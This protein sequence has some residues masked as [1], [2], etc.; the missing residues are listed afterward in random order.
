MGPKPLWRPQMDLSARWLINHVWSRIGV[1]K[2]SV[3][4][5]TSSSGHPSLYT[6]TRWITQSGRFWSWRRAQSR[7]D[8]QIAEEGPLEHGTSSTTHTYVPPWMPSRTVSRPTSNSMVEF[9]KS[10]PK[11]FLYMSNKDCLSY[12]FLKFKLFCL[13]LLIDCVPII[14]AHPVI[15]VK[16]Q[17][18]YNP[19]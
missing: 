11:Y 6:S 7:I 1:G 4:L 9:L 8:R 17:I 19:L 15:S 3:T 14:L 12:I 18:L 16:N 10:N 5:L 13:L 2:I